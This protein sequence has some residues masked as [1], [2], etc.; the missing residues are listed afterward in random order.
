MATGKAKTG[1]R[2][3]H[4]SGSMVET[5]PGSEVWRM[6]VTLADGRQKRYTFH[7]PKRTALEFLQERQHEHRH[8]DPA[9][10][11]NEAMTFGAHLDRWTAM[12][13]PD[14]APE[15]VRG[16]ESMIKTHIRPALGNIP[17]NELTAWHFDDLYRRMQAV[18]KAD[19]TIRKVHA[20]CVA[21]L[22]QARK[23]KLVPDNVAVDASK[24][25]GKPDRAVTSDDVPTL[26][27]IDAMID[28]SDAL[29][30]A[31][32]AAAFY[33]LVT[34]GTRRGEVCGLRWSAVDLDA[35]T[36]TIARSVDDQGNEVRP[37]T[38]ASVR[39]IKLEPGCVARLRNLDTGSHLAGGFVF[40]YG[41]G[42]EHF[43]PQRLWRHI[44]AV[45]DRLELPPLK[46]AVHMMRNAVASHLI[47]NGADV[48]KTA[49]LLGH[50]DPSMTLDVYAKPIRDSGTGTA[51]ILDRDSRRA[52]V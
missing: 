38:R 34:T 49:A 16:R 48:V 39:T 6:R 44:V 19:G 5:H 8:D 14:L 20:L 40:T 10:A 35:G 15:T 2:R 41:D 43:H 11:R 47:D 12:S 51:A 7:G 28:T 21:A 42:S 50:T 18:G 36:A 45:R 17:L 31:V 29:G 22:T 13:A 32:M 3:E 4:G 27:E 1:K 52:A 24:V 33:F 25:P 30:D 23:W 26:D 37:K 9:T 46:R